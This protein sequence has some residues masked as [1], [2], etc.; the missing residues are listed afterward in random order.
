MADNRLKKQMMSGMMWKFAERF[1]AQGVSFVVSLVLARILMPDDYG[2]IAIIN[3]FI[4]IA[5]V[6]LTSGLN[7]ALI[8]KQDADELDFSTMFYCNLCMSIVLYVVLFLT[9]PFMAKAYKMTVLTSAVRV[10]AL[11]LPISAFQSIQIA[12]VSRKMDFKKFFFSTIIGTLVSAVVGIYMAIRGFGVWAL[13][14]QYL[15]NTV[16]DTLFLFATVRWHPRRM[17]SWKRAKPLIVYGSRVMITDLIGTVFNNLGEFIVGIKYTTADLAYYTK[18]KQLPMLLKSNISTAFI[19][20]LFPGISQVNDDAEKVKTLTRQS[21][22]MLTYVIFPM[23]AG[24]MIVAEPLTIILYT[25]KW[26][27]MTPFIWIVCVEALFSIPATIVLQSIKAVGRSDL[28]LYSEFVKKPIL[29]LSILIALHF[30]VLAV[31]IT[32]PINALIELIIN[33]VLS[34]KTF[35]YHLG[36]ILLD[37]LP[38]TILS[39]VMGAVVYG[40]SLLPWNNLIVQLFVQ[41]IVGGVCYILLSLCSHNQEFYMILHA[42]SRKQNE[43]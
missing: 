18:G 29:L 6:L 31:A 5:D 25:R 36:E 27:A 10:F 11:R 3:I 30:G 26:I 39:V 40:I 35:R 13:I 1:V 2:V 7:T 21:V 8:Q 19:S 16:I 23:M 33:S 32:L 12:Y 41:V 17:F 37:F 15:T 20:V 4:T 24:L 14:A 42:V 38:A 34:G 43:N 9:A 22:R 28:M